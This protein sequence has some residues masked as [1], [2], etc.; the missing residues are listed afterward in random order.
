MILDLRSSLTPS[1]KNI[2]VRS[3]RILKHETLDSIYND[4]EQILVSSHY[5]THT[6]R[7]YLGQLRMFL[8]VTAP[9]PPSELSAK[10]IKTYIVNLVKA[11]S[12]RS[13]IDQAVNSLHFLYSEV[14]KRPVHLRDVQRPVS[15]RTPPVILTGEE[16]SRIADATGNL[17]H[18]LIILLAYTA[19]LRTSEVVNLQVRDFDHDNL[20]ISVRG[21]GKKRNRTTIFAEI[22]LSPIQTI[23]RDKKPFCYLFTGYE[24]KPLT[25]RAVSKFFKIALDASGIGKIAT[26]GTLRHS[27]TALILES[28]VDLKIAQKLLGHTRSDVTSYYSKLWLHPDPDSNIEMCT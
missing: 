4:C 5:S 13:T 26:P 20:T 3:D 8:A 14:F 19:G 16:V 22:L 18:K 23:T 27:F 15:K 10:E 1:G 24:G 2:I 7:A 11:G 6:V 25:P 12:S 21:N 9:R 17:K 28:G